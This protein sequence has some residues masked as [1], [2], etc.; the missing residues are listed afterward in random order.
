MVKPVIAQFA[1]QKWPEINLAVNTGN[2]TSGLE[3]TRRRASRGEGHYEHPEIQEGVG[4]YRVNASTSQDEQ[5]LQPL[6]SARDDTESNR[7][8][9]RCNKENENKRTFIIRILIYWAVTFL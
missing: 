2:V 5:Y 3:L 9:H 4:G 8:T 6:E 7:V 1:G